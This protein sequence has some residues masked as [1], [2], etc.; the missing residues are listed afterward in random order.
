MIKRLFTI[1]CLVLFVACATAQT[2][3]KVGDFYFQIVS[4]PN[5][6]VKIVR[7]EIPY[8]GHVEI[9]STIEYSG[10][11]FKVISIKDAFSKN[12]D[13]LSVHIPG[14]LEK[15]E[16]EAFDRCVKL[17]QVQIDEG[18]KEIGD[19]AFRRTAITYIKLPTSVKTLHY[20]CFAACK[21]LRKVD[22]LGVETV[23]LS[24][25]DG[26]SFLVDLTFPSSL[27][28][29]C[30]IGGLTGC[31]SL[32]TISFNSPVYWAG[33]IEKCPNIVQI[34]SNT[35]TP[36]A[37]ATFHYGT[38]DTKTTIVVPKG[39]LNIY[40]STSGW[41]NFLNI[42]EI[43]D[44][45]IIMPNAAKEINELGDEYFDG[46]NGRIIDYKK[47]G[48][49]YRKA[50]EMGLP[51][52]F[53]NLAYNYEYGLGMEMNI[54]EAGKL[55]RKSV[56]NDY[57]YRKVYK[58]IDR[59]REDYPDAVPSTNVTKTINV[60]SFKQTF[61]GI[62]FK[63]DGIDCTD[64]E[65]KVHGSFV[66]VQDITIW[67]PNTVYLRT[68]NGKKVN[69]IRAEGIIFEPKKTF[70]PS[71]KRYNFSLSFPLL[72]IGTTQF[73]LIESDKAD[74]WKFLDIILEKPI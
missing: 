67:W 28:K 24:V 70:Y 7:G 50:S 10:R 26:C 62:K 8:K 66:P 2:T 18:I 25:F 43:D 20:Q 17:S 6:T 58:H 48:D 52:A 69:V 55:Y 60:V 12:E 38:M 35:R 30:G 65:M 22:M 19:N 42:K 11:L 63:I 33:K 36:K 47:A 45:P 1:A 14:S 27:K 23:N 44:S 3:I 37:N 72:P 39:C 9:P 64:Y 21:R 61:S 59:V 49:C 73:D 68:K 53:F 56:D 46:K 5:K 29:L 71:G 41:N 40:T 13:I 31:A 57:D 16:T 4:V 32:R 34:T 54:M 74:S 15:I 51:V